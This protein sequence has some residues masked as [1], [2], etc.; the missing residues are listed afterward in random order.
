MAETKGHQ[1]VCSGMSCS[2][3]FGSDGLEGWRKKEPIV[4]Q[5]TGVIRW[6]SEVH[7]ERAIS[8]ESGVEVRVSLC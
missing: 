8:L 6:H 1:V 3:P 5:S 7:R 2:H 4:Q